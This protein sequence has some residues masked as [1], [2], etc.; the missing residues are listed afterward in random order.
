MTATV[1]NIRAKSGLSQSKF[2][3]KYNIPT[4]S[5]QNWEQGHSKPPEYVVD[6]LARLVDIDYGGRKMMLEVAGVEFLAEETKKKLIAEMK[7]AIVYG[8]TFKQFTDDYGWADWMS[9][10]VSSD[11]DDYELNATE[12]KNIEDTMKEAWELAE[13][14][15]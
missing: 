1:R 10:W 4:Q 8:M 6:M 9:A 13:K 15:K 2:A 7:Q 5:V 12:L 11:S 14:E 3:Q